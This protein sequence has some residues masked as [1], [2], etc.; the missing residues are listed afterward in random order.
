VPA[1]G[2]YSFVLASPSSALCTLAC[3]LS[4]EAWAE[5]MLP[6]EDVVP[7]DPLEPDPLPLPLPLEPDPLPPDRLPLEPLVGAVVMVVCGVVVV[8]VGVVVVGAVGVGVVLVGVVVV[9]VGV[10]VLRLVWYVT[11]SVADELA[12]RLVLVAVELEDEASSAAVS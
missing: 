8:R 3:A 5:G 7:V 9:L 11:N 12:V 6:A 2:A 4:T 10:V 1:I